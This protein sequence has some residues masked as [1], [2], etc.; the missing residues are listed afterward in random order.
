MN[1]NTVAKLK[2]KAPVENH[3]MVV[4]DNKIYV[5]DGDELV[6]FEP[7]IDTLWKKIWRFIKFN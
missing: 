3:S 4:L 6:V 2:E 5:V 1:K 7:E